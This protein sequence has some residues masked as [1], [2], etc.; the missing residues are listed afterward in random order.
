M[1]RICMLTMFLFL[2][3]SCGNRNAGK[4][5][6]ETT[7]SLEK[8]GASVETFAADYRPPAGIK[9]QPTIVRTGAKTINVAAALKHVRALKANEIGTPMLYPTGVEALCIFG[10]PL[11]KVENKWV[12]QAIEGLYLLDDKYKA[13]RQLVRNDVEMES[14]DGKNISLNL[15]R[16][17]YDA[18]YDASLR[19]LRASYG[20]KSRRFIANLSWD[21]LLASTDTCTPDQLTD[22][23]PQPAK[24]KFYTMEGGYFSPERFSSRVY[25]FGTKGDT[26]CLFTVNDAEDYVPVGDYR[27]AERDGQVYVYGGKP[28]FLLGYDDTVYELE[29][30]STLKAVWKLDFGDLKRPTGKYVVESLSRNLG[31]YWF[32]NSFMETN[33]YVIMGLSEGHDCPSNRES[34]NVKLYTLVYDKQTAECFSLPPAKN[35]EGHPDYPQIPFTYQGKSLNDHLSDVVDGIPYFL[36]YGKK[37]KE[38]LA[39]VPEAEALG[40]KETVIVMVEQ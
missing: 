29:D 27:S 9:Y 34:N 22:L 24:G 38:Q 1:N 21:E 23:L 13:V 5:Q 37:L 16:F 8:Q 19:Q 4:E 31:D 25:T 6:R 18:G 11:L 14:E 30:A 40:E 32:I 28:R 2:L 3:V 7:A 15:K 10:S 35:K 33:R 39:D 26:L 17:L 20:G 36:T 12:L